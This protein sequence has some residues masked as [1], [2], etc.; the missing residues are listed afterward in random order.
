MQSQ[1][2][3]R[4]EHIKFLL[5]RFL[6]RVKNGQA[7]AEPL[8]IGRRT[9]QGTIQYTDDSRRR[10]DL[11]IIGPA[12]LDGQASELDI[13]VTSIHT[14]LGTRQ[15]RTA[16]IKKLRA[17]KGAWQAA[18]EG[19]RQTLDVK[20]QDKI[21]QYESILANDFYPLAF[22]A[23]GVQ[24]ATTE[25]CFKHWSDKIPSFRYMMQLISVHLLRARAGSFCFPS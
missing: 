8:A 1:R 6:K 13:T 24:H 25:R 14:A 17:E 20:A 15:H 19:I 22:S 23:G 18:A 11:R 10:G 3:G 7:V 21:R 12:A 16:A 9:V 4:H 5:L 2:T